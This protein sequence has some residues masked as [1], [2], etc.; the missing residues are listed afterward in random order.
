LA[1]VSIPAAFLAG[2]VSF[3]S[4]CVLPLV[5]GYIS[6]ITGV[7]LEDLRERKTSAGIIIKALSFVI[8]F[9]LVFVLLGASA[10]WIG[11]F[12]LEKLSIM[13]K[14]AGVI[15]VVFGLHLIGVFRIGFLYREKRIQ[16]AGKPTSPLG[17]FVVGL[18]FAFGWTPCIGP[19]LAGIIAY[20]GTR[21]TV[22]EGIKLLSFYS[23]GIGIPFF[24]TAVAVDRFFTMFNR[25]KKHFRT[26]ELIGGIL[27]V[28]MG[29]LIFTKNLTLISGKIGFMEKLSF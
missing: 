10:T 26:I 3:L 11:Q 15:V 9:S 22:N 2:I 8:G 12:L 27:L 25:V 18:A 13:M 20:A 28:L 16:S 1:D 29:I 24:L 4:P 19:V 17:A 6:Y 5:P 23:L 7:S 21:E 14:I